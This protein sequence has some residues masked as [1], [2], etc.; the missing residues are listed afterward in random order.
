MPRYKL[1]IEYD[2]TP[3]VGWQRQAN[4]MSVQQA[5]EDAAA[6]LGGQAGRLRGAGRTDAG[7][8]ATGQIAHLDLDRFYRT[9]SVRDAINAGLKGCPIAILSA[10]VVPDTFDARFS[11]VRRFYRY[12]IINRRA[13]ATLDR[14]S[15]WLVKRPLDAEAMHTAAQVLVGRH[16]FSTFRDSECQA[17]SPVRTL[18]AIAVARD[19]DR[20]AITVSAQSFLHRQVRSM[21]G[22][23]EHVG[24]GKW[25]TADLQAALA[26]A[27]RSRC[28]QVAPACGLYLERVDYA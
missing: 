11:A 4:G 26:A 21:V 15:V 28:G 9:D 19:A 14:T 24:T 12:R 22:S 27:D 7:V 17:A 2:G 13:P 23:L 20:I 8:H 3:F 5:I 25:T 1:V 16:D 10:E 6:P 18:D